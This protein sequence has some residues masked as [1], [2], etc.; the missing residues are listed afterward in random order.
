MNLYD[1]LRE[2]AAG[3]R[4]PMHMPGHKRAVGFVMENPYAFDITE[5]EGTDNLH[6][7]AGIIRQEMERMKERYGTE[8]TY[9][10]VNGSTCGI[11]AA[12][13]ACC[14][15]GDEIVV[16]RNCHR[17]VYHAM[18][19]LE[20]KPIYIYPAVDE[21]TG[22][23]LGITAGQVQD[24]LADHNPSCVV[25]TSP[26]YEGVVSEIRQIAEA[27]HKRQIPLVVDE[28]HGAHFAWSGKM[29]ETAM[30]QGADLVVES[31]H[32]TLP[33]LTQTGLLHRVTDRVPAEKVE[34]YLD[35]YETSSPS[36]VLMASISQCMQWLCDNGKERFSHY[37]DLLAKFRKQAE[38][39]KHL[40]LWEIPEK[41]P[42][43]LIIT[44][45]LASV[46]GTVL[47]KMLR[48]EY[49]IEIEMET[50]EY[51]I[52]MTS[53]ADTAEGF[54]RL[55]WA[56][57]EID[58]QISGRREEKRKAKRYPMSHN[59]A[60]LHRGI[61]EALGNEQEQLPLTEAQG[62]T[63]AEYAMIYPPGIPFVVPGEEVTE[64]VISY[65]REAGRQGLAFT[66]LRDK[67]GK[68]I[69]VC[70]EEEN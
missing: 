60:V 28:A 56:L 19:L 6:A 57:T 16:A 67:T 39:W 24:M 53:V 2:Y 66:G 49:G 31:L 33:A 17:S 42:S 65:I 58:A 4:Y 40:S 55:A 64:A 10:L 35:I 41:E 59:R 46:T 43:K 63:A 22:I 12:I 13:S 70:K 32:K 69:C 37:F 8:E 20:L 18:E 36:Y 14:R 38:R 11:L 52:V 51:L 5:V 30:Q 26:T 3:N 54:Q 29:P 9:L 45:D 68:T 47:A 15:R 61:Y 27:A 44:T 34:H 7:P 50:P 1:R 23:C 62:K 25:I 48:E 21:T